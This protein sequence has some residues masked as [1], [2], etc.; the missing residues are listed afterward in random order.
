VSDSSTPS[1]R[2]SYA[3]ADRDSR[4]AQVRAF[5]DGISEVATARASGGRRPRRRA[6]ILAAD[7][8]LRRLEELDKD[9]DVRKALRGVT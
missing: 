6:E 3:H 1:T 2:S 5:F 8:I 7:K 4:S 9:A